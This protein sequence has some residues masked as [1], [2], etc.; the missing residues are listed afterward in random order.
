M[1]LCVAAGPDSGLS[2]P[3]GGCR[4]RSQAN[5]AYRDGAER[6]RE[7]RDAAADRRG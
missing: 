3:P 2:G 6:R 4:G 1:Q 5:E 7:E